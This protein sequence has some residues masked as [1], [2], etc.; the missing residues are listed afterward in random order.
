MKSGQDFGVLVLVR[1]LG[2]IYDAHIRLFEGQEAQKAQQTEGGL[3]VVLVIA[4]RSKT[5]ANSTC[6]CVV[7]IVNQPL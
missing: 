5:A 6:V 3:V 1:N 2:G 4:V 7:C